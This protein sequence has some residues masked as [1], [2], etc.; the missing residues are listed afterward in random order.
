ML[1]GDPC[2]DPPED[3]DE[4]PDDPPSPAPDPEDPLDPSRA[5]AGV[6]IADTTAPAAASIATENSN[7]RPIKR[8]DMGADRVTGDGM[9][10]NLTLR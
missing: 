7:A 4:L 8:E 9:A 3:P 5:R 10:H 1:P 2:P 6:K